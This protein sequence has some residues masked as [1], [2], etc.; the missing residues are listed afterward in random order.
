MHETNHYRRA[1]T[2]GIFELLDWQ[3]LAITAL[4]VTFVSSAAIWFTPTGQLK[5]EFSRKTLVLIVSIIV[6]VLN[7]SFNT[8]DFANWQ[9]TISSLLL[10]WAFAVLFYTYLGKFVVN[11]FFQKLKDKLTKDA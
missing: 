5:S 8:G 6:T 2:M 9:A 7:V 3:S 10:T 11:Y 1:I 4:I